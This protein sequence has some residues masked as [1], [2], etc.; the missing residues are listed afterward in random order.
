MEEVAFEEH[1]VDVEA[2]DFQE[3]EELQYSKPRYLFIFLGFPSLIA[4]LF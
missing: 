1:E 4:P 3:K 2:N